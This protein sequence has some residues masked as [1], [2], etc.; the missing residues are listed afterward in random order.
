MSDHTDIARS[1]VAQFPS[2]LIAKSRLTRLAS[3]IPA[4]VVHP[5]WSKP[6]PVVLWFHGRTA[7]KELDSGR[8]LRWI[9]GGIAACA[10]DLPGHGERTEPGRQEPTET[11]GVLEQAIGEID[12]IVDALRAPEYHGVL[13]TSRIAIGGMSAGGMIALR[14]LCDPHPF[15][16]ASVEATCGWLEGL[17][18][19]ER[20]QAVLGPDTPRH[21][22][23]ATHPP[24]VVA[25][26]DTMAHI[27]SFRPIP[28]L[29][30]HSQGDRIIP[31]A[32]QSYFIDAL[33]AQ[34]RS[35][36]ADEGQI[37]VRSWPQTGAPD[38][39]V[40]F[41]KVSHEAKNVQLEFLAR[42]LGVNPIPPLV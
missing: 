9:R 40:G 14:R 33:R 1:R 27:D 3:S 39:H 31:F 10:I 18:F 23:V 2:A 4:L 35:R 30:L 25:R 32:I 29:A 20:A 5:D 15:R 12:S 8:Y 21:T 26:L 6:A 17:Y 7:Y 22:W 41:G 38:E 34:Y 19:P 28:L 24:D 36:K 42:V 37:Q 16:C 13:D 11:L